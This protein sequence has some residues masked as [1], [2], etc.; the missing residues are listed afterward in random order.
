MSRC[1]AFLLGAFGGLLPILV[2]V[3][4]IDLAPIIDHPD[5]LTLGNYVGY[6][7]RVAVLL[8]L[9]GMMALLN[10]DVKQPFAIVQLGIAAPALITSFI[11]GATVRPNVTEHAYFSVVSVAHAEV[12]SSK[13]KRLHLAGGLNLDDVTAG[14]GRR[15]D[16]VAAANRANQSPELPNP[17]PGTPPGSFT[18]AVPPSSIPPVPQGYSNFCITPAGRI[19]GSPAP[20]GSP[21]SVMSVA[22]PVYGFVGQ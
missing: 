15:L 9:G 6:G 13:S 19:P 8:L 4:S 18:Q 10:G 12:F 21:C 11:N 5:A 22:G 16:G 7:I 3:L 1:G 17:V 14:F 2:S 20:I